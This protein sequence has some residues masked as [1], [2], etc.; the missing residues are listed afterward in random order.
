MN[1]ANEFQP[2]PH[3]GNQV[4]E[5]DFQFQDDPMLPD[6]LRASF[7]VSPNPTEKSENQS[8]VVS[9]QTDSDLSGISTTSNA[10]FGFVEIADLRESPKADEIETFALETFS[11]PATVSESVIKVNTPAFENNQ[12][13]QAESSESQPMVAAKPQPEKVAPSITIENSIDDHQSAQPVAEFSETLQPENQA[14]QQFNRELMDLALAEM[15]TSSNPAPKPLEDYVKTSP[16]LHNLDLKAF[17][18]ELNENAEAIT[19]REK[20]L[21]T[22]SLLLLVRS[23]D[24]LHTFF[25]TERE[26]D[27]AKQ[28]E[29]NSLSTQMKE[30]CGILKIV[31][32]GLQGENVEERSSQL[33]YIV[34]QLGESL[35]RLDTTIV[36][37][38]AEYADVLKL[39]EEREKIREEEDARRA[40]EKK[41]RDDAKR[42]REK[43][44][45]KPRTSKLLVAA[46]VL[47]WVMGGGA[48]AFNYF[49]PSTA[50]P[51]PNQNVKTINPKE[52]R[53]GENLTAVRLS[54][55]LLLGIAGEEWAKLSEEKRKENL[56][57]LLQSTAA[58]G[59]KRIMILNEKNEPIGSASS[60]GVNATE[61]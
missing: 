60:D 49:Y 58:Q 61:N 52:L 42:R 57:A 41:I 4:I 33:S 28:T 12:S 47:V 39:K 27:K 51:L 50:A 38:G 11:N 46:T 54:N 7:K 48:F 44:Q 34:D 59:V 13:F 53:G 9:V 14:P 1:Q 56:T 55:Q 5:E 30:V 37:H 40:L 17:F 32:G 45:R 20:N 2:K 25:N 22:K 15:M 6:F 43:L 8:Q 35:T 16:T 31:A 10:D 29:Y 23:D 19:E 18:G 24:V 21:R 3:T 26:F 36:K